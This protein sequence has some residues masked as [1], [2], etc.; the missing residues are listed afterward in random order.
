MPI[1]TIQRHRIIFLGL[2]I[3]LI[4][5]LSFGLISKSISGRPLSIIDEHVHLDYV[6]KISEGRLPVQGDTYADAVMSE[7]I[8]G[9]GHEAGA[10][11]TCDDSSARM[12]DF[13]S[14]EL[15]TA[16]IHYPTY[17][18]G[19]FGLSKLFG[20]LEP[21][22][23][24]RFASSLIYIAGL[25]MLAFLSSYATRSWW[26]MHGIFS[27]PIATTSLI[28]MGTRINPSAAI[29]L[30]ASLQA[31]TF[32]RFYRQP[33]IARFW[34]FTAASAAAVSVLSIFLIPVLAI[35][36]FLLISIRLVRHSSKELV[37]GIRHLFLYVVSCLI[38][39]LVWSIYLSE[40][41]ILEQ[42]D[43][44]NF[45]L[46]ENLTSLISN[47]IYELFSLHSPWYFDNSFFDQQSSLVGKSV[48]NLIAGL[49]TWISVIT[50]AQLLLN[51]SEM[52][53][54]TSDC[55][56]DDESYSIPVELSSVLSC[57]ALV[58]FITYPFFLRLTNS[59]Y[60]GVDF[61]IVTRYGATLTV[62]TALGIYSSNKR[63]RI[64]KAT[65]LMSGISV[66]A[67][68]LLLYF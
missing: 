1:V 52:P 44:Y 38:P 65:S 9:V 24:Y 4:A 27:L 50:F 54:E 58:S 10:P 17:Y 22:D 13:P 18:L 60:F 21:I 29:L 59:I 12:E 35:S 56:S 64:L 32:L 19:V 16:H 33:T 7:W 26:K 45:S 48:L 37:I 57:A 5:T 36:L 15:S 6:I 30:F 3:C 20:F 40:S 28:G 23:S 8:C 31:L 63:V 46:V 62:I 51:S 11:F 55:L 34:I 2:A 41:K 14:G 43:I 68:V 39:V 53:K 49:T 67:S 66:Y 42:S 61:G 47:L 25:L